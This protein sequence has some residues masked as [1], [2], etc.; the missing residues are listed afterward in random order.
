MAVCG[1]PFL[2]GATAPD[3][4]LRHQYRWQR[5]PIP[6]GDIKEK[7]LSSEI[8]SDEDGKHSLSSFSMGTC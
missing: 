4:R 6:R 7:N 2:C 1:L 5:G 3:R 8:N